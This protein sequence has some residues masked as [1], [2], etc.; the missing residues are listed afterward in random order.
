MKSNKEEKTNKTGT[1]YIVSTPIG[2]MDDITY[3]AVKVLKTTDL[4]VCEDP[5]IGA[6][7]L[8]RFNITQKMDILNEQNEN[9]KTAELFDL[10]MHGTSIALISDDGTPI[11]ADPGLA[12]VQTAIRNDIDIV[13]VPGPSSI[14][15][16][17]VRSGF[18]INQFLFAGFLS[19]DKDERLAQLKRLS[20]EARTVVLLETPYRLMPVLEAASKIMPKRNA[21]IGCNLT[22]PYETH[23]YGTFS[24]L[25]NKF[26][27][28][29]FK[30]EFV[31]CFEGMPIQLQL[32]NMVK[33]ELKPKIKEK[34]PYKK[35]S[36][37]RQ[38]KGKK[39]S[40][41]KK[42]KII[43]GKTKKY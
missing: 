29:N 26:K 22:M 31:I 10:L 18:P 9:T 36:Q 34:S 24:E 15:T 43:K 32:K 2:N 23:H 4:I 28:L 5:K 7:L 40:S 30:G 6:R 8:H 14:I 17:L 1:L 27:N 21:Y 37:T 11:L 39:F 13:V 20:D 42:K 41:E 25:Y 35:Q 3:R 16:A 19:R 38:Y 33:L 12:L